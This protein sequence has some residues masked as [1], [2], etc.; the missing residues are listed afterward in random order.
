MAAILRDL[1]QL[2]RYFALHFKTGQGMYMRY[3]IGLS[4]TMRN[5]DPGQILDPA[6]PGVASNLSKAYEYHTKPGT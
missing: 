6:A 3:M 1:E 2:G 5:L 4:V